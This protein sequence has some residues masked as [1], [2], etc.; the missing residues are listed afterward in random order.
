MYRIDLCYFAVIKVNKVTSCHTKK[1]NNKLNNIELTKTER[2]KKLHPNNIRK[3][4]KYFVLQ[5]TSFRCI[6]VH[7]ID[8]LTGVLS[9]YGVGKELYKE[10][11]P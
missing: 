1:N 11:L 3:F 9:L 4:K 10:N 6:H 2:V 8:T 5:I 7:V